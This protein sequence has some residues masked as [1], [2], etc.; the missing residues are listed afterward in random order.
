MSEG[1]RYVWRR[2]DL[3]VIMCMVFVMGTF[4]MN[5]PIF[6]S[7][8]ALEFHHDAD[9][10]GLL[11][12]FI[13]I[14]SLAGAL[15]AARRTQARLRVSVAAALLFGAATL[16]SAA[17]P[18]FWSYAILS[19]LT[20]FASL[21]TLTTANGYVQ[22]STAPEVRGRVVAIYMAL[23]VGGTVIGAPTV[24]WVAEHAG[25]RAGVL[26][27]GAAGLIVAAIGAVWFLA[28]GR[29]RRSPEAR[30]GLEV[31]STRA[32]PV[33]VDAGRA[34]AAGAAAASASD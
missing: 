13:A 11:T 23:L 7:T 5:F 28:S 32:I 26:V 24:G 22:S 21:T 9:G 2:K 31:L 10:F 17:M 15:L 27:G 19:I 14:G 34:A 6:A 12:S 1:F 3:L 20:G 25:A 8:M 18:D 16:V 30:F 33:Q 29:V 4:G